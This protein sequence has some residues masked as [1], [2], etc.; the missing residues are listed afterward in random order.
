MTALLEPTGPAPHTPTAAP[1]PT[2]PPAAAAPTIAVP[3][4][5]SVPAPAPAPA[6]APVRE[7]PVRTASDVRRLGSWIF[8]L[9][10]L[11][12]WVQ[13]AADGPDPVRPLWASALDWTTT[14]GLLALLVGTLLARRWTPWAGLLTGIPLFS[15]SVSCPISGHHEY[16][17]WWGVQLAAGAAMIALSARQLRRTRG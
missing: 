11:G 5:A 7:R 12:A 14:A 1:A 9:V 13:P 17:A 10:V 16:A 8:A 4:P 6:P 3:A 2:G 15:L